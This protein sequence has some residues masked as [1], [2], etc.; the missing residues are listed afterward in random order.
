MKK[1]LSSI[2]LLITVILFSQDYYVLSKNGLNLRKSP[3]DKSEVL[4]VVPYN[5]KIKILENNS[6]K[7]FKVNGFSGTYVKVKYNGI[8]GYIFSGFLSN[9]RG[10]N[11]DE[12]GYDSYL[13][14][15]LIEINGN[16]VLSID[17][18]DEVYTFPNGVV[19]IM[20]DVIL[21]TVQRSEFR[22]ENVSIQDAF[23]FYRTLFSYTS[24][25]EFDCENGCDR[26]Y[27]KKT[28]VLGEE[29]LEYMISFSIGKDGNVIVLNYLDT[30]F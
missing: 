17:D 14:K 3:S 2:L 7:K 9:L 27:N 18:E 29:R 13:M 8:E 21:S 22:F 12:F 5:T 30:D 15:D 24:E 19:Y 4:N 11:D 28:T 23:L 20:Y 26:T 25:L 10:L 1:I 16:P 6:S